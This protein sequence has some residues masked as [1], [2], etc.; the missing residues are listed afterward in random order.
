MTGKNQQHWSAIR[1]SLTY[2]A[3]GVV[4]NLSLDKFAA[5]FISDP[6]LLV[7]I[8]SIKVWGFLAVTA[9]LLYW[10][11]TRRWNRQS[12][13]D[14]YNRILFEES[15][16]GLALASKKGDLVD[17]NAAYANIIGRSIEE[18]LA[19]SYWEI[20][21]VEYYDKER[22]ML[23]SLERTGRYGPFEK[24]YIHKDGHLV[25]VRLQGM[26]LELNGEKMIWSSVEDI[27]AIRNEQRSRE[28]LLVFQDAVLD[29]V[30]DGLIACDRDAKITYVNQA[31]RK[32][33]GIPGRLTEVSQWKNCY[34]MYEADGVTPLPEELAPLLRALEGDEVQ[35]RE[36]VITPKSQPSVVLQAT[37]RR[38]VSSSG[39]VLG[40]VASLRD[41]TEQKTLLREERERQEQVTRYNEVLAKLI[42][43]KCFV[44]SDFPGF[45]DYLTEEISQ[46]LQVTR[47]GVWILEKDALSIRCENLWNSELRSHSTGMVL[48]AKDF[49]SYFESV[50]SD[51]VLSFDDVYA[52]PNT[53]EFTAEYFPINGITSM[54]DAPFHFSGEMAGVV[55]LEHTGPKRVWKVEEKAFIISIA[56]LLS[57]VFDSSRR[58]LLEA[59]LERSKKMDALGKLSGGIA[60]DYNNMLGVILGYADILENELRDQQK[61]AGYASAIR[62]A[63]E[64]GARLTAKLLTFARK[65]A[66][67]EEVVNLNSF[68]LE[69]KHMLETTLTARISL[70]VNPAPGLWPVVLNTSDLENAILNLSINAM[71]AMP[72][73]GCLTISTDNV[74]LSKSEAEVLQVEAGD[75]VRLSF[76]DTGCGMEQ[77]E[78]ELIF[79]PFYTTKGE[80][81]TGLGLAQVYG[82]A[83]QCGGGISVESTLGE[84]S[85]FSFFFPRISHVAAQVRSAE[86]KTPAI[87]VG[88]NET[89]LVVDDEPAL[90]QLSE[91]LLT[92]KGYTVI[93][94]ADGPGA[95]E[96]LENQHVDLLLTDAIM[97][98]IDGY[99]LSS[100]VQDR[101]PTVKIQIVTGYSENVDSGKA[102]RKLVEN[103]LTKPFDLP[104][105][106]A[107]IRELL[108]G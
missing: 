57:V 89:I 79:D 69:Q 19:L 66:A 63:G 52:E 44:S 97:G 92:A 87:D 72:G 1:I 12:S 94:A 17:V 95:I 56:D 104:K 49:P 75:Y 48:L 37:G 85:Q 8:E 42:K 76:Q 64:R 61:L 103:R 36:M 107:R 32:I 90:L 2:V 62:H 15:T 31:F 23:D 27:S 38:L 67:D 14:I 20:T 46:L 35:D 10:L 83:K 51:R 59:T 26:F 29:C 65:S 55:C 5:R 86:E 88:G 105:Y 4:L 74:V 25:D 6:S 100:I 9:A 21:P 43:N 91:Q 47:V 78:L 73:T 33:H 70:S 102:D 18:V 101:W 53:R 24:Q 84:G 45:L 68:L 7:S 54:L 11:L 41:V 30:A 39:E 60:H 80:M 98:E 22:E 40:A 81:G 50:L 108:D 71:H 3:V 58:L 34:D 82:F 28:E 77:S 13:S 106:F 96:V 99:E 16:I 93:C